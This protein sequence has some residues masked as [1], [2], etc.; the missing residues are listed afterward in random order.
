M[1]PGPKSSLINVFRNEEKGLSLQLQRC[2]DSEARFMRLPT[3]TL[4]EDVFGSERMKVTPLGAGN[5]VGRSCIMV[6][7]KG[8]TIMVSLWA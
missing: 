4:G 3:R 8:K 7:F 2:A 1:R 5:E 6:E